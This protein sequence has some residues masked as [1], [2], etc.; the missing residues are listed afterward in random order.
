MVVLL[1][2]SVSTTQWETGV[3]T[4]G[5]FD[6]PNEEKNINIILALAR[7]KSKVSL[8]NIKVHCKRETNI[9]TFFSCDS[10]FSIHF[11]IVHLAPHTPKFITKN[12]QRSRR[13]RKKIYTAC[14][15]MKMVGRVLGDVGCRSRV[16]CVNGNCHNINNICLCRLSLY[17]QHS[18]ALA[19][20]NVFSTLSSF[21]Y[22]SLVSHIEQNVRRRKGAQRI[23]QKKLSE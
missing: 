11:L 17:S 8:V 19:V 5:R 7:P 12:D 2:V 10:Y 22:S 18:K 9:K 14:A 20:G 16:F 3:W 4:T 23:E 15:D 21:E 6:I 13:E 1:V